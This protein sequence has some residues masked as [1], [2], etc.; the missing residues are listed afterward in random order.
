MPRRL[1]LAVLVA[2]SASPAL[3]QTCSTSWAAAVDGAWTDASK[4]TAGVPTASS[5][6]CI[7][8]D[9]TYT[10]TVAGFGVNSLTLGTPG[11]AGRQTLVQT[12]LVF[13]LPTGGTIAASGVFEW[14]DGGL[15]IGT[16]TNRGLV[17]INGPGTSRGVGPPTSGTTATFRNEGTVEHVDSGSFIVNAVTGAAGR[18]ENAGLWDVQGDGD[19]A[20]FPNGGTG[21]VVNEAS[22]VFR[23]SGGT[24][25]AQI[26]TAPLTVENAG[27]FDAQA[28]EI[29]FDVP[30]TH[31]D[32]ATL[33]AS[34]GALLRFNAGVVTFAGTIS[35]APS[36]LVQLAV[37]FT[38]P[39]GSTWAFGGTGMTW[40][41][42]GALSGGMVTNTGLV[43]I[44][45]GGE[46]RGVSAYEDGGTAIFRN[47]GTVEFADDG[48]FGINSVFPTGTSRVENAGLWD[49]QGDGDLQS[50]N[51]RDGVFS[52]EATGIFRK[53]GGTGATQFRIAALTVENAGT[54]DAQAGEI[55][56][57]VPSSH[58]DGAVL[59]AS[60]GA[61]VNFN[62]GAVTFDGTVSGSPTGLV[63]LAAFFYAPSG[64]TWDFGG[65]GMTW[66]NN[67]RLEEG[68]VVNT[69]LVRLV[70]GLENRG[71]TA[72]VAG[73][74]TTF[75]NEGTVQHLDDGAFGINT[76]S[77]STARVEN[78]GLWEVLGGGDYQ[79]F[80]NRVGV[81]A[82][83][84]TGVFRKSGGDLTEFRRAAL[85]VENA[86]TFDAQAGEI[87]IEV[88][89]DHQ[90]GGVI[91]GA[92]TFSPGGAFT[93]AGNTAPGSPTATGI[94]SWTGTWAPAASSSLV[95]DLGGTTAGSG[96]DQLAVSAAATLAGTL[97]LRVADGAALADGDAFTV[98][99][100]P[101][102]TG[103]FSGVTE[104]IGYDFSVATTATSVVV[105]VTRVN[106]APV[107]ASLDGPASVTV[108][109][110]AAFTASATDADNQ[111][112]T[113]TYDFGDGSDAEA[114]VDLTSVE[115]AFDAP[116]TYTVTVSVD[117]GD[118]GTDTAT[119]TVIVEAATA[120]EETPGAAAFTVEALASPSARP[121]LRVTL[122]EAGT[123]RANVY[124]VQGRHVARLA[125]ESHAAGDHALR[126][127][128]LA[129]GV[130]VARVVAT[131]PS[132]VEQATQRLVVMR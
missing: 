62:M 50:F 20:G 73:L 126:L 37:D 39:S 10:V 47:E 98:L 107:I 101:A 132:G 53:S 21:T 85:M 69:G 49:V 109:D 110:A 11:G 89:F 16:L 95:V 87:R 19:I 1:L 7:T 22:G 71:V 88:P 33:T 99:T 96:H 118:G 76:V 72:E 68:A 93:H 103:T 41:Q 97:D 46:N 45:G 123:L 35:G 27:T 64:A 67:G 83:E 86:G 24:G 77:G 36:G 28:G 66:V 3:A 15:Q 115:H 94:L 34:A 26:V 55:R 80:D 116:G 57:D 5:D 108:G 131:G 120:D 106:Q 113:Y 30:S 17:Q 44:D 84:A 112:L 119:A 121:A 13:S 70:G 52:N 91:A 48:A 111:P 78:A 124:D 63:Q 56:F 6:A 81:F 25:V 29:R 43:R 54:F 90:A 40:V 2:L 32:G 117:D 51:N 128:A 4:W 102:V 38:A 100:A 104:N 60:T 92:A 79:S 74:A 105:T 18:L 12:G 59:T 75:R 31:T 61:L 65:T 127:P 23:K 130:Y 125:D 129:P 58:T 42:L 9:G 114:G 8:V 122:A 82:N 14:R